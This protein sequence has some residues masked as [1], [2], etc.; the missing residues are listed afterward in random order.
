[1]TDSTTTTGSLQATGAMISVTAN[2]LQAS[3]RFYTEGL[4]F[5]VTQKDEANGAVRF[6]MLKAG[7]VQLGIGQDDFARGRDRV[8]G[9]GIRIWITT[10]QDLHALAERAKAAGIV[11][12]NEPEALPW[13]PLAFAIRDPDGFLLTVANET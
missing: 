11:L 5:E 8:K 7:E 13:G 12:D 6:V 4:G 10:R 9:V 1:M 2:D 3:L